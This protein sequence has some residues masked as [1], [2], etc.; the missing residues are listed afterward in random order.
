MASLEICLSVALL[1]MSIAVAQADDIKKGTIVVTPV[2]E[3]TFSDIMGELVPPMPD[4]TTGTIVTL[5]GMQMTLRRSDGTL[6][7]VEFLVAARSPTFPPIGT[8]KVVT[9]IGKIDGDGIL[10]ARIVTRGLP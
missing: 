2:R 8:G 4:Q 1:C 6:T 5:N 7:I 10:H 3:R 9:A